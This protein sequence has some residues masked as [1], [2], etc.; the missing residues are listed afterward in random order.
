MKSD[1]RNNSLLTALLL[2]ALAAL[3]FMVLRGT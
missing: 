3:T 1:Y 2:F